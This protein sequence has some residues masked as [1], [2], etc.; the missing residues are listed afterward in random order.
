MSYGFDRRAICRMTTPSFAGRRK[1]TTSVAIFV[2]ANIP[3]LIPTI[4]G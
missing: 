4:K 3:L 2:R 1:E